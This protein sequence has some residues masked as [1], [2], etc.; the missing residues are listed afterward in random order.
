MTTF[1][2]LTPIP[3]LIQLENLKLIKCLG[4]EL[5]VEKIIQ[6]RLTENLYFLQLNCRK[7]NEKHGVVLI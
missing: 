6:L 1:I 3:V 4:K 2:S 5:I 7:F